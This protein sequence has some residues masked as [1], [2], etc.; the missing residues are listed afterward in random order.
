MCSYLLQSQPGS[1]IWIEHVSDQM[2]G[3]GRNGY[4]FWKFIVAVFYSFVGLFHCLCLEWRFSYQQGVEYYAQ[5]PD[6]GLEAVAG[7][8]QY[9]W[10]DVVGSTA[11]GV[12]SISGMDQFSTEAEITNFNLHFMIEEDVA[13]FDIS[14]HDSFLMEILQ[15]IEQLQHVASGLELCNS[16]SASQKF[17]PQGWRY[18]SWSCS[19]RVRG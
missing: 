12:P 3:L 15:S 14:M 13:Q 16:D 18:I 19:G 17:Y 9:L 11:G 4:L 8:C 5:G 10:G 1:G 2:F 6:I 7:L